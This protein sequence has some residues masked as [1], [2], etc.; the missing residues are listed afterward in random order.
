MATQKTTQKKPAA[1]KA[2]SPAK[3]IQPAVSVTPETLVLVVGNGENPIPGLRL[4][5]WEFT[6]SDAHRNAPDEEKRA[7]L[8]PLEIPVFKHI[9]RLRYAARWGLDPGYVVVL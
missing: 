9:E 2:K 8:T 7:Y 1:G 4:T 6:L 5:T 3:T